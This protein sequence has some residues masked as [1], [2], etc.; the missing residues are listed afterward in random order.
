[1]EFINVSGRKMNTILPNDYTFFA[2]LHDLI[3][4]EPEDCLRP[5]AKG[6]MAA[7]GIEKVKPFKPDARMKK[8]LTDA[9]AIGNAA[10]RAISFFPREPGSLIYGEDSAW[11]MAYA[12]KNTAFEKN[13][14]YN[15]DARALLHYG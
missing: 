6:M 9:A 1:M 3:Q 11:M 12:N 2:K 8:I 10:A 4:G 14:A 5:E 13:G 15:L 7:I